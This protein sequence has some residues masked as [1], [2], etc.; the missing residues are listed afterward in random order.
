MCCRALWS[1][2]VYGLR[3]CRRRWSKW[4]KTWEQLSAGRKEWVQGE[5]ACLRVRVPRAP[6]TP[7][8]HHSHVLTRAAKR[9]QGSK[10]MGGR[11]QGVRGSRGAHQRGDLRTGTP[12]TPE[13][14]HPSQCHPRGQA[15]GA[16]AWGAQP[17]SEEAR[18]R[19]GGGGTA[20]LNG[21]NTSPQFTK[22]FFLLSGYTC[23]GS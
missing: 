20:V 22:P 16:S 7:L 1:K 13:S 18:A 15:L 9:E 11:G 5:G 17:G 6:P 2:C 8:G 19:S 3:P 14:C 23:G 10:V 12:E 4:S 21:L